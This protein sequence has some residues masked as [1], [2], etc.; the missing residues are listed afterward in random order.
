MFKSCKILFTYILAKNAQA[1]GQIKA[2]PQ[3][4]LNPQLYPYEAVLHYQ[5]HV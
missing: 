5:N 4:V 1:V 3:Q 2:K